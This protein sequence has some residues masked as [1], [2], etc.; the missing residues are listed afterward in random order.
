MHSPSKA[1]FLQE[2]QYSQPGQAVQPGSTSE[3]PRT[4]HRPVQPQQAFILGSR[5]QQRKYARVAVPQAPS[6][7]RSK[8]DQSTAF[9]QQLPG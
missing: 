7:C 9:E 3:V 2:Q 1:H 5:H 6:T 4:P 8:V